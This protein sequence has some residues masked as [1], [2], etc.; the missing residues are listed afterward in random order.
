MMHRN[1]RDELSTSGRIPAYRAWL[2]L[3]LIAV[4]T[5]GSAEAKKKKSKL[6]DL[7]PEQYKSWLDD[8]QFLIS[9][10]EREVFLKLEKDYQRD[11]FIERFWKVRDPYP[12]T[13]RNELKESY[14]ARLRFVHSELGGL[15]DERSKT[16]LTNGPPT[17][18]IK[19][20]CMPYLWPAEVWYYDGS[21]T[22][23]FEFFLLFY[24]PYGNGGYRLWQPFDGYDD[25][26]QERN[27]S[28]NAIIQRCP[29][30]QGRAVAQAIG[31]INSQGGTVGAQILMSR[32]TRKPKPPAKEWVETFSTYSTDLP[33]AAATFEAE[34]TLDYP[35]RHLS[36]SILQGNVAVPVAALQASEIGTHQSYDLMLNGE[37]LREG[38]LFENFRY[39]FD[40]PV[41]EV[42]GEKLPLVFQRYLRPAT[43]QL[44]V[45]VE[46]IA[47]GSFYR[48]EREIEVPFLDAGPRP[49]PEDPETA[50]LLAEANAAIRNGEN[51]IKI[52]PL[53]GEWQTGLV[54]IDAATTGRDI[55]RVNFLLD[56]QPILTKKSPPYNVELDLGQVPRSRV[57]RV[58]AFNELGDEVA[59][60][61]KMINSGQH[62]FAV[63]LVEPRR[64]K[65]YRSS[66]RAQAD[67]L[68]PDGEVVQR[69]EFYL[70][71]TLVST[72]YQPPF[73]QPI[74][75]PEGEAVGYVR[76]VAYTPDEL[77][78]EDLVF[79]NAPE[80]FE[81][82]E[83]D[84]VELY[85]AVLD[86]SKRP[87]DTLSQ[88]D[89][90]V[91]ED[92]VAQ[93]LL[94]FEQV[95]NLPIHAA[96]MLDV[97]ASMEEG[98]QQAQ[99]AALHFF[100]QAVTP[101]DR[102]AIV[103]FND[104]PDLATKFTNDLEDLAG[105]LAGLK[106]ERGT[107]LYDSLI[108]T[109]YY[110]NGIRGQRAILMLSDGKDESSRFEFD[111][112]LEYARRA[113]VAIYV[114][115][116]NL[117]RK[118]YG[119]ISKLAEETGGRSFQIADASELT[120]VYEIIQ[121]ELRS[122]YLL[123]YQSSNTSGKKDFRT[124]TVDLAPNGLE[125]KTLRGY[126]P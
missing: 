48:H 41:S 93:E 49:E 8:V 72:L 61:E 86:R 9:D 90:S 83:V 38:K 78:T 68:L 11:A 116:L 59:S 25:L 126:Y 1:F 47:S 106:A 23:S 21:D 81:E 7:L 74:V 75:L 101:K 28:I 42:R 124:I 69:V 34:L 80:N 87:V 66:V 62:R 121:H 79:I 102:A 18:S 85:T 112:A 12:R 113:G 77:S 57:L 53:H 45:K 97:S 27:L 52:S 82:I 63:R 20:K 95:R 76:A 2:I 37:I 70:N 56:D 13:S 98:L 88:A 43:Y 89:F 10:E 125:A 17:D 107:A 5:A 24:Q 104:H 14:D 119:K 16:V 4:L 96:I 123:A 91:L 109:L 19:I 33:E 58:E 64:N 3:L 60:D 120:G 67:V 71:E 108:F 54:R 111:D 30:D 92:G 6:E 84:F 99:E 94:R 105:G 15:H 118:D 110:F 73:I 31:F 51:T 55:A 40:F 32:I 44:I 122:R 117:P 115:G 26:S 50:R 29:G 36:R 103:T 39:R 114:I 35:G 100:E 65:T 46:D 22:V